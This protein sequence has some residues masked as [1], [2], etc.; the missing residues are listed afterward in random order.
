MNIRNVCV[1]GAGDDC[2]L[3]RRAANADASQRRMAIQTA[4]IA[5]ESRRRIA[6]QTVE[7]KART[8]HDDGGC[9]CGMVGID[10]PRVS[11]PEVGLIKTDDSGN[12]EAGD[13]RDDN[14]DVNRNDCIFF[15]VSRRQGDL[16]S[17]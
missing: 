12:V 7:S 8:I 1:E 17:P 13:K 14:V 9:I 16:P 6:Q 4:T 15:S 11:L 3:A 10:A 2:R 5:G